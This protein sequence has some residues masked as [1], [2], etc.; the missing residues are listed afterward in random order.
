MAQRVA[1]APTESGEERLEG[2]ESEPC[3]LLWKVWLLVPLVLLKKG[4]GRA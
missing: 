1:W 3:C 2:G 4:P